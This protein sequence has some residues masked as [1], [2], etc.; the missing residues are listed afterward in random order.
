MAAFPLRD[1][2]TEQGESIREKVRIARH[3]QLRLEN[4]HHAVFR[5][6]EVSL[7]LRFACRW[8]LGWE[9]NRFF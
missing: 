4:P 3:L 9:R 5:R 6:R 8:S 7:E 2:P 1:S